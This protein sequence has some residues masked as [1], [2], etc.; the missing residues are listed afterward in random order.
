MVKGINST[1]M[2]DDVVFKR[3]A[4]QM[5]KG[6]AVQV[7][8]KK[9]PVRRTNSQRLRMVTFT[10]NSEEYA[11]IEQN[12]EKPSRWGKVAREGPQSSAVQRC[13]GESVCCGSSDGEVK[14]Y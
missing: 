5:M 6:D 8:G 14:G 3:V 9:Y 2:S 4:E 12:P 10:L 11:A 1:A 7:C 13:E